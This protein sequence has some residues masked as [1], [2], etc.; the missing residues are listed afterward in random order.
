LSAGPPGPIVPSRILAAFLASVFSRPVAELLDL[1]PAIGA[2]IAFLGERIDCKI[3]VTDLY[4]DLHR[5]ARQGALDRLPQ[6]L[7]G[8]F[9]GL[10]ERIDAVLCWDVFDYLGPAAARVLAGELVQ[11]L[12]PG[13]A[14]LAFFGD[15]RPEDGHHTRYIIADESHFRHH[16]SAA[17]CRRQRV[18]QNRDIVT[19]FDGLDVID[20]VL[21]KS[22]VREVLFRKPERARARV[23]AVGGTHAS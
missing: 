18:L 13:G 23:G 17:P 10:D 12:R 4:A 6:F 20:S 3:H 8:R 16:V 5:H 7:D 9:A 14:L 2:N 11:T 19:L 21:L 15:G 22:G 1:G